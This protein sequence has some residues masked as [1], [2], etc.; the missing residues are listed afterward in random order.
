[1]RVAHARP[2]WFFLHQGNVMNKHLQSHHYPLSA[3]PGVA[4]TAI[5]LQ[6]TGLQPKG[7]IYGV[8]ENYG[9]ADLALTINMSS[10]NDD[11]DNFSGNAVTFRVDGAGVTTVTIVPN[12]TVEFFIEWVLGM[13]TKTYLQFLATPVSGSANGFLSLFHYYGAMELRTETLVP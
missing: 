1:V 9:S 10:D 3:L 5:I 6:R 7:C 4:N 2:A 12:G 11:T 13:Q 8:A